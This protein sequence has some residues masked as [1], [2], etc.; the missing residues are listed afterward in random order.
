MASHRIFHWGAATA[1]LSLLQTSPLLQGPAL[2]Q[3]TP[4]QREACT[5]DAFRLCSAYFPDSGRVE[6]CLRASGPRLS[7]AC[8]DVFYP[9]RQ[10][11]PDMARRRRFN[12]PQPLP[13]PRYDDDDDD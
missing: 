10:T 2:A 7:Q 11:P 9:Q 6:A 4:Q 13:P 12:N 5:P 8:Y 1:L 3:G